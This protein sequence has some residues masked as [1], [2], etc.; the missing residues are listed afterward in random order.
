MEEINPA[1]YI[2]LEH[3][4]SLLYLAKK[5]SLFGF[6]RDESLIKLSGGN[7]FRPTIRNLADLILLLESSKPVY[8][9]NGILIRQDK[10]R[11]ILNSIYEGPKSENF[12]VGEH[13]D[14]TFYILNSELWMAYNYRV[15][16]NKIFPLDN[17]KINPSNENHYLS[18]HFSINLNELDENRLPI[19]FNDSG[20]IE[21]LPPFD[22]SA[23]RFVVDK[24]YSKYL[25]LYCSKDNIGMG[26][27]IREA[28]NG[29]DI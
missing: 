29:I 17:K 7:G 4:F 15:I 28:R 21:F 22:N 5:R 14:N 9:G 24:F 27:G 10:K 25:N 1:D 18:D 26:I 3:K 23:S 2:L 6:N 19:K 16:N 12:F 13:L 20:R 8:D 11:L